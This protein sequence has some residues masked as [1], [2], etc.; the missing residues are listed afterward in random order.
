[1]SNAAYTRRDIVKGFLANMVIFQVVVALLVF[2]QGLVVALVSAIMLPFL[3]LFVFTD[4]VSL[5]Q[6]NNAI[7]MAIVC[8]AV[9]AMVTLSIRYFDNRILSVAAH[10]LLIIY[11]IISFGILG[12]AFT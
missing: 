7:M 12:M 5:R 1:M 10:V 11:W 8:L 9:S 3:P 2:S 6:G 4:W